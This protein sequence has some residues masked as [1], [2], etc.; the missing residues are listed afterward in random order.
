MGQ[1]SGHRL[2]LDRFWNRLRSHNGRRGIRRDS[3][4]EEPAATFHEPASPSDTWDK[5]IRTHGAIQIVLDRLEK[6]AGG[7]AAS[8]VWD[9]G[10]QERVA[11]A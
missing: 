1:S 6:Q 11:L 7:G 10:R 9:E 8:H 2:G 3:H 5:T 4:L